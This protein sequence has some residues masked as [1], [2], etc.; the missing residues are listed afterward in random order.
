MQFLEF[1]SWGSESWVGGMSNCFPQL[2]IEIYKN[3]IIN[4]NFDKARD[5]LLKLKQIIDYVISIGKYTQSV[6]FIMK[7]LALC[8]ELCRPPYLTLNI[9]EK[10]KVK[11]YLNL[12]LK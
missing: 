6:K 8:N 4:K 10:K 5:R 12:I 9:D 7:E 11:K 2:H 1:C 3:A